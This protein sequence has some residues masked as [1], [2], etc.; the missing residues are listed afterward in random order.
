MG[1]ITKPNTFVTGNT[2]VAALNNSNF[3]TIYN[4]FNGNISNA[5]IANN[6]AIAS[7]KIDFSDIEKVSKII[8][9]TAG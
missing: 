9:Q 4:E 5:N 3:D 7:S 1:L 6:A 8:S 2:I